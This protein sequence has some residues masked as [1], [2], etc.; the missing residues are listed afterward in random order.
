MTVVCAGKRALL[1]CSPGKRVKVTQA[2]WGNDS[3]VACA[4]STYPGAV[5]LPL[6]TYTDS[7]HVTDQI[8]KRCLKQQNCEVEASGSFFDEG[9]AS[10]PSSAKHLRVWH[11]C[12]PDVSKVILSSRRA[13]RDV[14]MQERAFSSSKPSGTGAELLKSYGKGLG[15]SGSVNS[16]SEGVAHS[17][18]GGK[19]NE[20]ITSNRNESVA[21]K[22]K[23]SEGS[24]E[25]AN[26]ARMLD[27]LLAPSSLNK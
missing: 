11:E 1:Q 17:F 6:T 7:S 14:R 9:A 21:G 18:F 13:K 10:I 19:S 22:E 25:S 16:S 23:R 27:E 2:R 3:S 20:Q 8:R 4:N 5:T 12:I 24:E 26:L 15:S